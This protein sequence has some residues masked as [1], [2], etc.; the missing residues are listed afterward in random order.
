M[1]EKAKMTATVDSFER[2]DLRGKRNTVDSALDPSEKQ[3]QRYANNDD[4]QRH[5]SQALV[6]P[7][8]H[9]HR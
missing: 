1:F 4:E 3:E 2:V 8:L 7:E 6:V 5:E 9:D